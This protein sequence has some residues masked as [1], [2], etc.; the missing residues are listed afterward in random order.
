VS[1]PETF[2]QLVDGQGLTLDEYQL[3]VEQTLGDTVLSPMA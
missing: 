2:I 3:W 1:S